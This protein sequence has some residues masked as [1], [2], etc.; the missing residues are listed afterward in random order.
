MKIE[1]IFYHASFQKDLRKLSV[2]DVGLAAIAEDTFRK[3]PLDPSLGIHKLS[4]RLRGAWAIVVSH[5]IRI[6]FVPVEP[7]GTIVFLSVGPHDL[8]DTVHR[9]LRS[10]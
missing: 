3:T 5:K 9:R 6:I 8:Y 2:Q 10:L 7:A 4:G 1:E